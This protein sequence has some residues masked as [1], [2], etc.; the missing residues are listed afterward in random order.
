MARSNVVMTDMLV[1][2]VP[3]NS[4]AL[5][6]SPVAWYSLALLFHQKGCGQDNER[7]PGQNQKTW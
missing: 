7:N 1:L 6:H 4:I 5:S 2:M 3:P